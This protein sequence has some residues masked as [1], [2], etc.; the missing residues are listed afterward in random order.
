MNFFKRKYLQ[1]YIK[2]LELFNTNSI[3]LAKAKYFLKNEKSLNLE[4]P[5]EFAEKIQWLKFNFYTEKYG[6]LVDKYEVREHV[7]KKIGKDYLNGFI[8]VYDSVEEI[9]L[10]KLPNQFALKGTH[11]SGYNIIVEDKS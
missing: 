2:V 11:G 8:A 6:Y 7:A 4:V 3:K 10:S 5:K 1:T 9:D